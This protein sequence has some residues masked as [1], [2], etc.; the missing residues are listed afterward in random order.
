M[1]RCNL[2]ILPSSFPNIKFN[3]DGICNI[4]LNYKEESYQGKLAL[5]KILESYKNKEEKYNCIIPLSGGKDSSFVLYYAVKMLNLKPI[6]V[7]YDSG[8]QSKL[9]KEN[10][11]NICEILNVPLIIKKANKINKKILKEALLI[12]ETAGS[13]VLTC[14]MC[15][16]ILRSIAINLAKK[17]NISL[18]LWGATSTENL[19]DEYLSKIKVSGKKKG[20]IT[21]LKKVKKYYRKYFRIFPHAINYY[22]LAVLQRIQIGV[23]KKNIFNIFKKVPFPKKKIKVIY[24]FDYI[25]SDPFKTIQ[26][27]EKEVKWKSPTN[28]EDRF[29]CLLHSFINHAYLQLVGI[30]SDGYVYSNVIRNRNLRRSEALLKESHI[31]DTVEEECRNIINELDLKDYKI[32]ML[33]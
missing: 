6:A 12:S 24:F 2:C 28:K 13:F 14:G 29:D 22:F 33:K 10:I 11:I 3:K 26:T 1:E 19:E 18:I 31:K 7:N 25:K 8:F 16:A 5:E 4:C 17:K 9:A 27:L 15:E 32:P 30:S 23:P 20:I 21:K